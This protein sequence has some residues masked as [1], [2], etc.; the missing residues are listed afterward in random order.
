MQGVDPSSFQNINFRYADAKSALQ[1]NPN[2]LA[3]QNQADAVTGKSIK[4]F[5]LKTPV[6]EMSK[7]LITWI[8]I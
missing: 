2:S 5:L 4:S 6:W 1:N 3:R 8:E 7:L